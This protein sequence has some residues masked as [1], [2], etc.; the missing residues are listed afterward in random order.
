LG[1]NRLRL[2]RGGREPA[3]PS[4]TVFGALLSVYRA[5]NRLGH[6]GSMEEADP[7]LDVFGPD[8]RGAGMIFAVLAVAGI[9]GLAV[10]AL[11]IG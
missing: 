5:K 8:D 9:L 11:R 7:L 2:V 10:V 1:G 3:G 4:R 6:D